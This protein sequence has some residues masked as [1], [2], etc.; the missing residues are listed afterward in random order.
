[1]F[2]KATLTPTLKHD[3]DIL[4]KNSYRPIPHLNIDTIIL[5]MLLVK[6]IQ[7]CIKREYIFHQGRGTVYPWLNLFLSVFLG[8]FPRNTVIPGKQ[9]CFNISKSVNTIQY[10]N[11]IKGGK[12]HMIISVDAERTYDKTQHLCMIK[13]VRKLGIK[14][15]S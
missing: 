3:K 7:Q 2:Y 5:N 10:L 14:R 8:I 12:N 15:N 11:R 4:T 6:Q 1:M 9:S 13:T